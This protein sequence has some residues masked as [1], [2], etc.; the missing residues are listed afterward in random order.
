MSTPPGHNELWKNCTWKTAEEKLAFF[1][2]YFKNSDIVASHMRETIDSLKNRLVRFI[3]SGKITEGIKEREI[4]MKDV[5]AE[6]RR[7]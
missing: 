2:H 5:I 1:N 6:I 4:T 7:S 3:E